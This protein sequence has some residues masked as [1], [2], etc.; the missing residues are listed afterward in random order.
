VLTGDQAKRE[1]VRAL[2]LRSREKPR[3]AEVQARLDVAGI[4]HEVEVSIGNFV[5]DLVLLD[6]RVI[7]EF[8]GPYHDQPRA[9]P[10]DTAKDANAASFGYT[11]TRVR[12]AIGV[13]V[14]PAAMLDGII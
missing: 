5:Y 6:A 3:Y 7:V 2:A 12:H 1:L 10:V 9:A 8:D 14:F 13:R 11:L 4:R